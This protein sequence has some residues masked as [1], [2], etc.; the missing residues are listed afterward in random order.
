MLPAQRKRTTTLNEGDEL[1]PVKD[2][3]A[4]YFYVQSLSEQV[5]FN[6]TFTIYYFRYA[7]Y[8]KVSLTTRTRLIGRFVG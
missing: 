1:T 5:I 6:I 4:A 8:F 2:A 3:L 7:N